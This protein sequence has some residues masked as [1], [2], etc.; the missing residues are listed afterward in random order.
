M[1]VTA[2][3]TSVIIAALLGWHEAH[4]PALRALITASD[5]GGGTLL[6]PAPALVE[7]YAVM[8]RLPAPHELQKRRRG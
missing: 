2:V 8:T 6:I 3:D 7:A 1:T 4:D 5:T